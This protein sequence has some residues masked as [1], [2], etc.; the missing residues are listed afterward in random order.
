[1]QVA[2]FFVY[3][4][5]GKINKDSLEDIITFESRERFSSPVDQ[6]FDQHYFDLCHTNN[7]FDS[8]PNRIRLSKKAKGQPIKKL[9]VLLLY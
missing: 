2:H 8:M 6:L 5:R 3:Q 9:M 4:A 7:L 1:M